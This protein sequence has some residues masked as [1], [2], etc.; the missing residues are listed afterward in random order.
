MRKS[1]YP[2]CYKGSEPYIF[3]SFSPKDK[4]AV[5]PIIQAFSRS[6]RVWYDL[7]G[8]TD[9]ERL[10]NAGT[11]IC[12]LSAYYTHDP[13]CANE[14]SFAVSSRKFI[15][16]V[17]L[18][19]AER[20]VSMSL[21]L[22]REQGYHFDRNPAKNEP[23]YLL[24]SIMS[25]C[26]SE[27]IECASDRP[28]GFS[29]DLSFGDDEW[30]ADSPKAKP[31]KPSGFLKRLLS[32]RKAESGTPGEHE[33]APSDTVSFSVL[34]PRAV[35][36]DS[37][38]VI[39]LHMY[40]DAQRETVDRAIRESG[41]MVQETSKG[42]F[43]VQRST[44][45]TARLESDDV[46]IRDP[47]ETQV[48][49]GSSLRFDF[50]FHVPADYSRSQIAFTCYIE[51]NGIPVTRLNFLTV[52]SRLPDRKA[53]PAKITQSDFRK[54]FISYSRKDEQ[55]MLAR[56]LGIHELAPEMKFWLDK[57]SIDAGDLWREEIRNAIDISDVLLLFWSVPASQ[58]KEVENEWR[59]GLEK[60]GLSFIAPVPLDPPQ[61]CPPPDALNALNFTV[62]A[63]SQNE[64]TEKLSFYNSKNIELV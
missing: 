23:E 20:P 46:E 16:P 63:F 47:L 56:V 24:A 11:F 59:Y 38:G 61:S 41:G 8:K 48:W 58:S 52:V 62:R 10:A 15:I 36:P 17:S 1:L 39:D 21:S 28:S 32:R 13:H 60:N 57:Q 12:I 50:S 18:S 37:Y 49:N 53:L 2:P 43:S 29:D 30:S 14:Y 25:D 31:E 5:L 44:S 33:K 9:R 4:D 3:F 55:R 7:T 51:Y 6:Y 40:T 54:A 34:S 35:A 19:P 45:V 22:S 42:G 26:A 64:I 27:L